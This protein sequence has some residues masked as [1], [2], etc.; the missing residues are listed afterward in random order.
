MIIA[1]I[2]SRQTP[3][4]VLVAFEQFAARAS[5]GPNGAWFRSGHADGADYAFEKGAREKCIVYLPWDGFNHQLQIVGKAQALNFVD[6]DAL[7]IVAEHEPYAT[8]CSNGVKLLKC[9]NVFQILGRDMRKKSDLVVCWTPGGNASGG[10]G[11]AIKIARR[12]DIPVIDIGSYKNVSEKLIWDH[13]E[14]HC[15]SLWDTLP[16]E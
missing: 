15:P 16:H 13:I 5:S 1:G 6:D 7:K 14:K 8:N 11:L 2:G 3:K 9:R 12:N 4:D 10:T